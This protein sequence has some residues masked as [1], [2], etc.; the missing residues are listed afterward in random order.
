[1]TSARDS[2]EVVER[3]RRTVA[4][5]TGLD[6]SGRRGDAFAATLARAARAAGDDDQGALAR[7]LLDGRRPLE[8]FVEDLTIGETWFFRDPAQWAFVERV[9]LPEARARRR[10]ASGHRFRAWSA[11]C[12]TGEEP[13]SLAMVLHDAGLRDRVHVV[14]TDLN[15]TALARARAA[16]FSLWSLRGDV[17]ARARRHLREA[18]GKLV[19]DPAVAA[20]VSFFPLNLAGADYPSPSRG[21]SDLDLLLCRNVLIYLDARLLAELARRLFACLAPGGW[22][23]AGAADPI[24]SRHAPF[25]VDA[26]P[27]GLAY[28]RPAARP[29]AI[30][31]PAAGRREIPAAL[32]PATRAARAPRPSPPPAAPPPPPGS[33][34]ADARALLDAGRPGDALAA[35]DAALARRPLDAAAH[36]ERAVALTELGR[37]DDAEDACRRALYL[38]RGEPFV[39]F[40]LAMLRLRRGD[41][42]AARRGFRTAAALASRLAPGAEVPLSHGMTAA[43]LAEAARL[44]GGGRPGVRR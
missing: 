21:L 32:R 23:L 26:G 9:V 20:L 41:E 31:P 30:A 27:H 3:L 15:E 37:V 2:A 42:G 39:H 10:G 22:L 6:L 44:A 11:A 43:D 16:E 29:A 38:A 7:A 40:F 34:A 36:F 24:L 12:A 1:V 19:L 35:L 25:E 33:A 17:G 18:G 13:Y 8:A 5:R 14:G 28:R 4:D